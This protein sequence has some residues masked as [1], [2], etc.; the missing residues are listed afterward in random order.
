MY[1]NQTPVAKKSKLVPKFMGTPVGGK[2]GLSKSKQSEVIISM[3][4]APPKETTQPKLASAYV[5]PEIFEPLPTVN[6]SAP[7]TPKTGLNP[8]SKLLKPLQDS[9]AR[10]ANLHTGF[11]DLNPEYTKY[12]HKRTKALADRWLNILSQD[13][14][15]QVKEKKRELF[16]KDM[17]V[18]SNLHKLTY[19]Q[20]KN[21]SG[22]Y[23]KDVI[24]ITS[25]K[26]KKITHKVMTAL[27]DNRE[28]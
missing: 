16:N 18:T 5:T 3:N 8:R 20:I 17:M 12:R 4:S 27:N 15:R 9:M 26:D 14:R 10:N 19:T 7:K 22:T 23:R 24:D 11:R 6:K 25:L 1:S 13:L 21:L 2:R 28:L